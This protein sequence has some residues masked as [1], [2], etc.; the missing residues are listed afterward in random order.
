VQTDF[1]IPASF[2]D[3]KISGHESV[4]GDSTGYQKSFLRSCILD[5]FFPLWFQIFLTKFFA[6]EWIV[7][8]GSIHLEADCGTIKK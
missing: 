8:F 6:S 7:C 2:F 1:C 3:G 5:I 4:E